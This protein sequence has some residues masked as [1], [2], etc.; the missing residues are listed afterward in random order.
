MKK[1][2]RIY[3]IVLATILIVFSNIRVNISES[4][5]IGI[6]LVN[7]FSKNYSKGDYVVYRIDKKYKEYVNEKLKDLDTV[8]QI[9]GVAGDEVEYIDNKIY[10]N[11]ENVAEIIY[12]IP[13]NSRK[14]YI[15]SENEFLT[16]GDVSYSVDGRYYGTIKKKDIKYKVHLIYRIRI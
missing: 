9:K 16:I 10:I 5:P 4:S 12:E 6:Y 11:K 2:E 1:I 7:R 15:I 8:K 13:I 3:F 14:K